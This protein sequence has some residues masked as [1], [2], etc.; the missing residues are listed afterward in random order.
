[1]RINMQWESGRENKKKQ[2]DSIKQQDRWWLQQLAGL[3]FNFTFMSVFISGTYSTFFA[4]IN[5]DNKV[6]ETAHV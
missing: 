2:R 6:N 4:D 1:M 5:F 3:T